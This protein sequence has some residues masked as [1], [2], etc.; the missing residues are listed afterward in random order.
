MKMFVIAAIKWDREGMLE[1]LYLFLGIT[2]VAQIW[3][4]NL[5]TI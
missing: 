1:K 5:Q 2:S 3:S 4:V